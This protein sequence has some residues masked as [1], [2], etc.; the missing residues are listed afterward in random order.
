MMLGIALVLPGYHIPPILRLG[1]LVARRISTS[2]HR[3]STSYKCAQRV[4]DSAPSIEAL[5][6]ENGITA[7]PSHAAMPPYISGRVAVASRPRLAVLVGRS[8]G[9][10]HFVLKTLQFKT[11]CLTQA[12]NI[13]EGPDAHHHL[14]ASH[15]MDIYHISSTGLTSVNCDNVDCSMCVNPTP[16]VC[17]KT[18]T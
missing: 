18:D 6:V 17:Q 9:S 8:A 15:G 4:H 10:R 5:C 3:V 1:G 14:K 12:C 16:K 11:L 2:A 7:W 13:P